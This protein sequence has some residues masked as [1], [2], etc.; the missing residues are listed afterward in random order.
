MCFTDI[1]A[2]A[3]ARAGLERARAELE[4]RVAERTE[5]LQIANAALGR[6]TE[7]KTR[8]LA[9]ASHDLLQPLHAARLFAAALSGEVTPSAQPMLANVDRSIAAA[10]A[11]LRALLDI[12]KLDAGGIRPVPTRFAVRALLAELVESFA[13]LAAEKRLTLRLGPGDGWLET[14]RN[15]LRSVVQNFL[16]N[17]VRYT[18][19]GGI[20][21]G[22]RR[23]GHQLRIEVYDSGSGIA[24]ADQER[25]FTEFERLDTAG[26]AGIGLGLAIARR[27][28]ALLGLKIELRSALGI[29]SRFAITLPLADAYDA[30]VE[31]AITVRSSTPL[32]GTTVLIVDDDAAIRKATA[33]LLATW[34]CRALTAAT[35]AAALELVA[36]A[37]RAIVDLDL[38]GGEEGIALIARLEAVR[39][40]LACALVT[41]DRSPE[42]AERCARLAITLLTKPVDPGVLADWLAHGDPIVAR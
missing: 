38:G 1:T 3:E 23:R 40:G 22:V 32:A 2:E 12:S 10:D 30:P 27:T 6:A 7:E 14:D 33:A 18:M 17:A 24:G 21:V 26:E 42:V 35:A 5:E 8:F 39:P 13:P 41:A 28:A 31:P 29:G 9:A 15:L 34:H 19:A 37:D 25:I 36:D 4:I 11:L 20:V 16:S